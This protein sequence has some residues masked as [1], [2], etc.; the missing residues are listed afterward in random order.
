MLQVFT[1]FVVSIAMSLALAHA[2]EW[3]G[4][5]R[6][7]RDTYRAV[8][9]IYYPGFTFGGFSEWIGILATAA[10][11]WTTPKDTAPFDW[12]A[13]ALVCLIAM[14]LVYWTVTHPVNKFWVAG[15]DLPTLGAKFFGVDSSRLESGPSDDELWTRLRNRWESSHVVRA[16]LAACALLAVLIAIA[17]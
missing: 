6:L 5:R 1:A 12:I 14:H 9:A 4:K 17:G 3:P 15:I 10:L 2:L 16:V 7:D 13:F 8:Q 11:L